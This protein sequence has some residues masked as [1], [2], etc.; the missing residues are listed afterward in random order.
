MRKVFKFGAQIRSRGD[1]RDGARRCGRCVAILFCGAS[2]ACGPTYLVPK[3]DYALALD[4]PEQ[5]P[6]LPAIRKS[7]GNVVGI[8]ASS[9]RPTHPK[10][11]AVDDVPPQTTAFIKVRGRGMQHPL[12]RAGA[13][14]SISAA[15]SIII[16][17][18]LLGA[19]AFGRNSSETRS[20]M[21][22]SGITFSVLSAPL[23]LT[24]V[25]LWIAGGVFGRPQEV[26]L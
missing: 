5:D 17:P 2:T 3:E 10:S 14:L 11:L 4:R 1:S 15:A 7:D 12:W 18:S 24:G 9:I 20:R 8:R 16:G 21:Y 23:L 6:V 19:A 22:F 13:I 26:P 25:P